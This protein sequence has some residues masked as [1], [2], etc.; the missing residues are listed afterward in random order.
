[1]QVDSVVSIERPRESK[2]YEISHPTSHGSANG[3]SQKAAKSL[4]LILQV[5]P[6]PRYE[7]TSSLS[8]AT[9]PRRNPQASLSRLT[10]GASGWSSP[11]VPQSKRPHV[12]SRKPGDAA[13]GSLGCFPKKFRA[14]SRLPDAPHPNPLHDAQNGCE[15][16]MRPWRLVKM[17]S[18]AFKSSI[19]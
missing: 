12:L 18:M 5:D 15:A 9:L 6:I 4:L 17:A 16:R 2:T 19:S 14:P 3:Q 13:G 1:M 8:T 7:F 10:S 11:T